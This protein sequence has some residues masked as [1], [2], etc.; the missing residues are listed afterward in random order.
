MELRVVGA[1]ERW[2]LGGDEPKLVGN[3]RFSMIKLEV[4][5]TTLTPTIKPFS[6][7]ADPEEIR[8][9]Q[10]TLRERDKEEA[11]DLRKLLE[12]VRGLKAE[13][14]QGWQE[15]MRPAAGATM[16]EMDEELAPPAEEKQGKDD[17][18]DDE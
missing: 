13:G 11:E 3:G 4:D 18:M 17:Q 9:E 6:R 15:R 1:A 7:E 14:V 10:A 2:D 16:E 5:R 8:K 12:D